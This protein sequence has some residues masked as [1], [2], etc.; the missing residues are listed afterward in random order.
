MASVSVVS[1]V[2]QGAARSGD[3]RQI[4]AANA[5]VGQER[6]TGTSS[7]GG[8]LFI[9]TTNAYGTAGVGVPSAGNWGAMQCSVLGPGICELNEAIPIVFPRP[10]QRFSWPIGRYMFESCL[11]WNTNALAGVEFGMMILGVDFGAPFSGAD[12]GFGITNDAGV[13]KY[14]SRTPNGFESVVIPGIVTSEWNKFGMLMTLATA[15]KDAALTLYVN[16]VPVLTRT[17]AT[18][19]FTEASGIFWMLP[20]FGNKGAGANALLFA[21]PGLW[22]GPDTD[23]GTL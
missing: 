18:W 6:Q 23:I 21:Q 20:A 16:D 3:V 4:I 5:Q 15:D 1:A 14:F 17:N 13:V 19:G 8:N 7:N 22:S 10:V 12:N 9:S 11:A 2:A